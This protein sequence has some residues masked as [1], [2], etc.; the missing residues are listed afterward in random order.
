M[1]VANAACSDINGTSQ[2]MQ[3]PMNARKPATRMKR[4][5]LLLAR[6]NSYLVVSTSG[7]V[8]GCVND[9]VIQFKNCGTSKLQCE[10]EYN[11]PKHQGREVL[12][13]LQVPAAKFPQIL[14]TLSIYDISNAVSLWG[15]NAAP[16]YNTKTTQ[17]TAMHLPSARPLGRLLEGT[18]VL[19]WS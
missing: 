9:C 17:V 4:R 14:V 15:G 12:E 1:D 19:C 7:C 3:C 13:R 2:C 11:R 6:H 18:F 16:I 5:S 8:N 10:Y